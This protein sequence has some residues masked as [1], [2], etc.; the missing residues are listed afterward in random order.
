MPATVGILGGRLHVGLTRTQMERLARHERPCVKTSRRD[1]PCVMA[2]VG[3]GAA[4]VA[5]G[6]VWERW[7]VPT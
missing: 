4:P 6:M 3:R 7:F 1:L 5:V 2:K